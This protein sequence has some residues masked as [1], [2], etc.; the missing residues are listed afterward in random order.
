MA[1]SG[2]LH[3][4]VPIP[5][6]GQVAP[7]VLD[8]I[9]RDDISYTQLGTRLIRHAL[10]PDTY[11]FRYHTFRGTFGFQ[12]CSRNIDTMRVFDC[13]RPMECG[14]DPVFRQAREWSCILQARRSLPRDVR[15]LLAL[16]YDF[17]HEM[18]QPD[19]DEQTLWR[20]RPWLLHLYAVA[21]R[22]LEHYDI[23]AS[24]PSDVDWFA[25]PHPGGPSGRRNSF[26]A[27][28]GRRRAA[29]WSF[30]GSQSSQS[31]SD[32]TV[33]RHGPRDASHGRGSSSDAVG[34]GLATVQDWLD[35]RQE[36]ASAED[37]EDQV[38]ALGLFDPAPGGYV[39]SRTRRPASRAGQRETSSAAH[40]HGAGVAASQPDDAQPG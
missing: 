35:S 33:V 10:L 36:P 13:L 24:S 7:N 39:Y 1:S 30:V 18:L 26:P 37:L 12:V 32:D 19:M 21:D 4:I 9:L 17:S 14:G 40:A 27:L 22:L 28:G 2:P 29:G 16:V 31:W 23:L 15:W 20:M 6:P 25:S 3:G 11:L 8:E 5:V 34:D 38:S